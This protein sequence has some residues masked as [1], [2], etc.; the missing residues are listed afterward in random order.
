MNFTRINVPTFNVVCKTT[1]QLTNEEQIDLVQLNEYEL[2][3]LQYEVGKGIHPDKQFK[4][5]DSDLAVAIIEPTGHLSDELKGMS[6]S[7][8]LAISLLD[9]TGKRY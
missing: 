4:V 9:L 1:N 6:L 3:T 2:R 8:T 5:I 7:Q